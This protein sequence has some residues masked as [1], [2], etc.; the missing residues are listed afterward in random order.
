[1]NASGRVQIS[2]AGANVAPGSTVSGCGPIIAG[3]RGRLRM[4]FDLVPRQ[5]GPVLEVLVYMHAPQI[6]CLWGKS[7]PFALTAGVPVRV[8]IPL[9]N[10]DACTTPLTATSMDVIVDG[11][12][13]TASRQEFTIHY[14]FLP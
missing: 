14:D 1:M 11:P 13:E 12:I 6:A 9:E 4:A 10:A 5:S 3:C 2:F 7:A 8:E